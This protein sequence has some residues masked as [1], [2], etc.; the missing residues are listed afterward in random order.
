MNAPKITDTI[1]INFWNQFSLN[2]TVNRDF[3]KN[4]SEDKY[5]YR[6]V[7][8]P[9]RKSNSVRE[10]F[11]HQIDV[12]KC[13]MDGIKTKVLR[14]VSKNSLDPKKFFKK[15]LLQKLDETD[16]ELIVILSDPEISNKKV[17]VPWSKDPLSAVATLWGLDSH[18][19]LHTGWNIAI[20]DHLNMKRFSSLKEM[21]A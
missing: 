5:D 2:R 15:E 18:E 7:D 10:S 14:F 8:T 17:K 6:M 4:V 16:K 3:Y 13:Y 12:Q 9:K 11:A 19:T 1:A 20:M 21:W